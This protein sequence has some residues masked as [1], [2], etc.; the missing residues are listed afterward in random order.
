[1]AADGSATAA[2]MDAL[3]QGSDPS[4]LSAALVATAAATQ[5]SWT[6]ALNESMSMVSQAI[7]GAVGTAPTLLAGAQIDEATPMPGL[8]ASTILAATVVPEAPSTAV[9]P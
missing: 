6:A 3:Q 8:Q 1:P 2:L 7:D 4:A 5:G 9:P